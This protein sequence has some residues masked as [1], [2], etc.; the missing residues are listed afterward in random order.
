LPTRPVVHFV[1]DPELRLG[2]FDVI[3]ETMSQAEIDRELG[4]DHD[5][6]PV[7]AYTPQANAT[8]S[9][10]QPLAAAPI[11]SD[12]LE[13]L[14]PVNATLTSPLMGTIKLDDKDMYTVGRKETCDIRL[15]DSAASRLHATLT[16]DDSEWIITDND[17]TNKTQVNGFPISSKRLSTGDVITI[18]TS[19]FTY[20]NDLAAGEPSP[21]PTVK[22]FL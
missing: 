9:A 2:R 14:R 11:L 20:R 3:G 5:P 21:F 10:E 8:I 7:R 22:G 12:D 18:G 1:T 4:L 16:H 13:D 17:A 15:D 6:V 19:Q